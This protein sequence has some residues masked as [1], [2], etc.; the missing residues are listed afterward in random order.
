MNILRPTTARTATLFEIITVKGN[1]LFRLLIEI[2]LGG[3]RYVA[4]KRCTLI[5]ACSYFKYEKRDNGC[6]YFKKFCRRLQ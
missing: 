4:G 6:G 3:G 5:A 1:S 2:F